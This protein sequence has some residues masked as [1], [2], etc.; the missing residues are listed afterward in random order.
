MKFDIS[1]ITKANGASINIEFLDVITCS[2]RLP[3]GYELVG[4]VSFNGHLTNVNGI[5]ELDGILETD[6][7]AK[8]FRCLKDLNGHLRLNVNESFVH[9]EPDEGSDAYTFKGNSL[10]LDSVF[11]DSIILNLPMRQVC[12]ENCKGFC[13]GCGADLN[14]SVCSCKEEYINPQMEMLKKLLNN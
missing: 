1:S 12:S 10:E 2:S 5:L 6:Y 4:P 7:S 3:E 9:G 14:E 11:E 8:C 13:A